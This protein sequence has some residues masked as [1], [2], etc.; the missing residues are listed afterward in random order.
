[1]ESAPAPCILA[2]CEKRYSLRGPCHQQCHFLHVPID[3]DV[4]IRDKS[5]TVETVPWPNRDRQ[6]GFVVTGV[7]ARINVAASVNTRKRPLHTDRVSGLQRSL[8]RGDG[9]QKLSHTFIVFHEGKESR[10]SPVRG[11]GVTSQANRRR[12]GPVC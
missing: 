4:A 3:A 8:S 6:A 12:S 9:W 11:M 1:M 5:D 7:E 10:G 2:R